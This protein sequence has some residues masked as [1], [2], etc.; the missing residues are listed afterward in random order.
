MI[1]KSEMLDKNNIFMYNG[2]KFQN[3]REVGEVMLNFKKYSKL[4]MIFAALAGVAAIAGC[5]MNG[6]DSGGQLSEMIDR[7]NEHYGS[8]EYYDGVFMRTEFD[9]YSPDTMR[10]LV[11]W[12]NNTDEELTFG[13]PWQLYKKQGDEFFP[14]IRTSG[15]SYGWNLPGYPVRPGKTRNHIYWIES[16][17]DSLAFGTYKIKT[18]FSTGRGETLKNYL[19]EAEFEVSDDKSKWGAS[20]LDFLNGENYGKYTDMSGVGSSDISPF[21][22]YKNKATYDTIITDGIYEYEIGEGSGKRGVVRNDLYEADGKKY[23]VYSY[24]RQIDGKHCSHLCVLD[25]TDNSDVKEIYK[26]EPFFCDYDA[27]F[28]IN[29]K[30]EEREDGYTYAVVDENGD[31][32]IDN[33]FRVLYEDYHESDGGGHSSMFAGDIG[34]LVHENGCFFYVEDMGLDANSKPEHSPEP[35][36]HEIPEQPTQ[37]ALPGPES[38]NSRFEFDDIIKNI[39]GG[40]MTYELIYESR[41][42]AKISRGNDIY[43][44]VNPNR[45]SDIRISP[46]DSFMKILENCEYI[47]TDSFDEPIIYTFIFSASDMNGEK[48]EI[49]VYVT[50]SC[51]RFAYNGISD[52]KEYANT[53]KTAEYKNICGGY[54]FYIE[55]IIP[56]ENGQL[57]TIW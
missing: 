53:H 7:I 26:S 46:L 33:K 39:S 18:D 36:V 5:A 43:Y 56:D 8:M 1:G 48:N 28:V 45:N 55:G 32:V 30:L 47:E 35:T 27:V 34:W 13:E 40:N 9:V 23:L 29:A 41:T 38:A 31:F 57:A 19:L 14:V 3:N 54:D 24:S 11:Y 21:R 22:V 44:P 15:G 50:H 2:I 49:C 4:I 37:P 20:A 52:G 16:F 10:I 12:E 42:D 51:V 25:I 6:A 17:A